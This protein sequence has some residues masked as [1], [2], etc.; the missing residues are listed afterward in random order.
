MTEEVTV[1]TDSTESREAGR[2]IFQE[3]DG[4]CDKLNNTVCPAGGCSFMVLPGEE[5]RKR[6]LWA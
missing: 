5:E 2:C 1:T 4:T 6:A 3:A